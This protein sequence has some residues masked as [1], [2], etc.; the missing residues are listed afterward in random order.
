M[1][2][3]G[4]ETTDHLAI[5]EVGHSSSGYN[6]A[7]SIFQW[8]LEKKHMGPTD[9]PFLSKYSNWNMKWCIRIYIYIYIQ[10]GAPQL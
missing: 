10:C 3:N 9:L 8:Q 7:V 5:L 6:P 4:M 1:S 2:W